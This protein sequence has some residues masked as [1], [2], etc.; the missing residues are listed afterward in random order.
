MLRFKLLS[1]LLA[2]LITFFYL[3]SNVNALSPFNLGDT[4]GDLDVDIFDYTAIL[5]NFGRVFN[6]GDFDDNNSV[7]IFDYNIVLSNFGK[8][9][10][11]NPTP[12][13]V[14]MVEGIA[15]CNDHD[16]NKWHGVVKRD[17]SGNITCTYGH[18]H[19]ADPNALNLVFGEPGSWYN[20]SGQSISYPWQTFA[21][22][23]EHFPQPP[24]DASKMENAAKHNGYKWFT[25]RN[26]P[27][28]A[29]PVDNTQGCISD[30]RVLVHQ[31]NTAADA[32]VRFHSY[33]FEGRACLNNECGTIK[34]GGWQDY[35]KLMIT[36]NA[37]PE[38]NICP[39]LSDN[40]TSFQCA[41]GA[42]GTRHHY[43]PEATCCLGATWYPQ[44]N[45]FVLVSA[46]QGDPWGPIDTTNPFNQL[47]EPINRF[48]KIWNG[49]SGGID[50]VAINT[51]KDTAITDPDGDRK[52]NY[53]GYVNR[54]GNIVQGCSQIGLDC[55]PIEIVNMP[56]NF[57]K[58]R[59][60]ILTSAQLSAT[61]AQYE[62]DVLSP[63]TGK[64][65]IT[66]PN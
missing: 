15:R 6:N 40:P 17:G 34:V 50:S 60:R 38:V 5:S 63:A 61:G 2:F 18:E 55:I 19:H 31:L 56:I 24:A 37:A 13:P 23:H 16:V 29:N 22:G 32:T 12:S 66:Y 33:S 8:T 51:N 25:R 10:N 43:A 59:D 1:Y 41:F 58:Y 26:I 46:T 57:Y 54:Y 45:P 49:S 53:R 64:S 48:N 30:F 44:G 47:Y 52:A 35:G 42:T 14:G 27:C 21:G 4:E 39:P 28:V 20:Q 11:S 3:S 7:D 65:L 62:H 9:Y 36:K